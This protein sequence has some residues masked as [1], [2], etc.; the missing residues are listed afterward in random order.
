MPMVPL[1][2]SVALPWVHERTPDSDTTS[3][4]AGP[5]IVI[6]PMPGETDQSPVKLQ[7]KEKSPAVAATGRPAFSSKCAMPVA[8]WA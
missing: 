1:L 5:V 4:E 3:K 2:L 8:Q 6:L 7:G